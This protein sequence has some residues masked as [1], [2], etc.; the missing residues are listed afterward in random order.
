MSE[1][2]HCLSQALERKMLSANFC[3]PRIKEINA[4]LRILSPYLA[5]SRPHI[6]GLKQIRDFSSR[7][8]LKVLV[9]TVDCTAEVNKCIQ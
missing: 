7:T 1:M 4:F 9:S 3:Q 5:E 2:P 8:E 6:R